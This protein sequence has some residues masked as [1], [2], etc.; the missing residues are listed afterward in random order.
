MTFII[1]DIWNLMVSLAYLCFYPILKILN[2]LYNDFH[3]VWVLMV[4]VY[5]AAL[6]IPNTALVVVGLFS[7]AI[8]IEI[9]SLVTILITMRLAIGTYRFFKDEIKVWVPT[10]GN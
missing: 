9:I 5:N 2:L 4:D 8:P 10:W 1:D 6:V 7:V 3:T